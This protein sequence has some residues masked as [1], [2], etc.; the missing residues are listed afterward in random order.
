MEIW[1]F[2]T[3]MHFLFIFKKMGVTEVL[4]IC[5]KDNEVIRKRQTLDKPQHCGFSW[6]RG[7][8]LPPL[9]SL[10]TEATGR[11]SRCLGPLLR[12]SG[13]LASREGL[14]HLSLWL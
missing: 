13:S 2:A 5:F 7:F 6:P 10:L 14:G 3:G 4:R 11:G 8:L 1:L 12:P 9:C